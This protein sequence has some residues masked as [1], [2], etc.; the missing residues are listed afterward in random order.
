[1]DDAFSAH[2]ELGVERGRL[3]SNAEPQLELTRT[4]VPAQRETVLRAAHV[5][6]QESALRAISAHLLVI[7]RKQ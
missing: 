3:V 4:L 5:V 6:E 2:Y 7:G 1:M